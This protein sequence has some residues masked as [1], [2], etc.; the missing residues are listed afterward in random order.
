MSEQL[1]SNPLSQDSQEGS[2]QSEGQLQ[3]SDDLITQSDGHHDHHYFFGPTNEYGLIEVHCSCGHGLQVEAS[4]HE[5]ID[6][7]LISK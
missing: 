6:G 5:I 7:K 1:Q 3:K 2:E 4:T